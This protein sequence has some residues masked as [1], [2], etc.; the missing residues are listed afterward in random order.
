MH[1]ITPTIYCGTIQ[2][3]A[4]GDS[5][6]ELLAS[7]LASGA[8]VK[9]WPT[10]CQAAT[11]KLSVRIVQSVPTSLLGLN[12]G[13]EKEKEKGSKKEPTECTVRS[14]LCINSAMGR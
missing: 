8:Q 14:P 5:A 6:F 9:Q 7:G 4:G 13:K 2:S 3:P 12:S 1:P 10:C 11:L